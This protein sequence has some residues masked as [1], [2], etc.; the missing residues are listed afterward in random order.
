MLRCGSD[1]GGGVDAGRVDRGRMQKSDGAREGEI[2]IREPEG[3]GGDLGK[4]GCDQDGGGLGGRGGGGIAGVGDEGELA[5]GGVFDARHA[6][7][8][9]LPDRRGEW[10]RGARQD[11]EASFSAW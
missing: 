6:G 3:G 2:G 7:D 1:D 4:V 5:G 11:R 9:G 10:R 8:L